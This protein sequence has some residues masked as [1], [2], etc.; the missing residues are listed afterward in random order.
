MIAAPSHLRRCHALH[1][2]T[3]RSDPLRNRRQ[4]GPVGDAVARR[5]APGRRGAVLVRAD[6]A[7]GL[8]R[9]APRPAQLRGLRRDHR[10]PGIRIRHLGRRSAR[11]AGRAQRIARPRGRRF[12]RLPHVDIVRAAPSA[13]RALASALARHRRARRG[14]APRA[15]VLHRFH[16]AGA[17]RRHGGGMRLGVFP[18]AHRRPAR[19]PRAARGDGRAALH[20]RDDALAR[21]LQSPAPTCR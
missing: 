9:A 12:L 14:R 4:E 20:R 19:E 16:R 17:A 11:S 7:G 5:A 8:P 6:R 1:D 10:R 3:R 18:R 21:V 15:A 2:S 13:G